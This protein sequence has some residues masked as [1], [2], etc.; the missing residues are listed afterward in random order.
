M[1]RSNFRLGILIGCLIIFQLFINNLSIFYLDSLSVINNVDL[2]LIICLSF[3]ADLMGHWYFGSHLFAIIL[4]TFLSQRFLISYS[5]GSSLQKVALI[6][7]FYLFLSLILL[8]IGITTHNIYINWIDLSIE[9]FVLCPIILWLFGFI[10]IRN[11]R[12]N[13]IY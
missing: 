2:K 3:I 9:V 7:I 10:N 13:L 11:S 12:T 8:F 1:H 4:L 6:M 5:L